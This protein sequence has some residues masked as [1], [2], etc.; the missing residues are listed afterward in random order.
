MRNS[1][2]GSGCR[3]LI[4]LVLI[5]PLCLCAM[6]AIYEIRNAETVVRLRPAY[7]DNERVPLEI[8]DT[9][10]VA[11][12]DLLFPGPFGHQYVTGLRAWH[13]RLWS[14]DS[15][16]SVVRGAV[17]ARAEG[18]LG[19]EAAYRRPFP[20][21]KPHLRT[22]FVLPEPIDT[23]VVRLSSDTLAVGDTLKYRVEVRGRSGK[24]I[25]DGDLPL[26]AP[27]MVPLAPYGLAN[28]WSGVG[29]AR[30]A[31]SGTIVVRAG[32]HITAQPVVV[33]EARGPT[34]FGVSSLDRSLPCIE[35][36]YGKPVLPH[37]SEDHVF[38]LQ[39]G[40]YVPGP[41]VVSAGR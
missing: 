8:G 36:L 38:R 33:R 9:L 41:A 14:I 12:G 15:T 11:D 19:I 40:R 22:F 10:A 1:G 25:W 30:T 16:G 24:S 18:A 26:T 39:G 31:G 13:F 28:A 21:G 27:P 7:A 37:A 29:V 4:G 2:P 6:L 3:G 35:R 23:I 5:V 32:H 17:Q 34:H 20:I